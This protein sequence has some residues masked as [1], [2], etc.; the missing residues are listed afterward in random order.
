MAKVSPKVRHADAND[1]PTMLEFEVRYI[2]DK[3]GFVTD[4]ELVNDTIAQGEEYV[5]NV[6]SHG[7]G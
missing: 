3:D 1:D 5:T 7:Q 6:L 2:R 4:V